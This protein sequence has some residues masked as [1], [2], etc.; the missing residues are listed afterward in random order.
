[1]RSEGG[2]GHRD[3]DL[4]RRLVTHPAEPNGQVAREPGGQRVVLPL[5]PAPWP[6]TAGQ[7]RVG[8]VEPLLAQAARRVVVG[9]GI[10]VPGEL[11]LQQHVQPLPALQV[12]LTVQP[13]PGAVGRGDQSQSAALRAPA[14]PLLE[15]LRQHGVDQHA[16]ARSELR[17]L[18]GAREQHDRCF[19]PAKL[20][21]AR[22]VHLLEL[23]EEPAQIAV[24][25]APP[26]SALRHP[27]RHASQQQPVQNLLARLPV[28]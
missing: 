3:H 8:R 20:R 22:L 27:Q 13:P 18:D 15:L 6:R 19:E 26:S 23:S 16:E 4:H 9:D 24:V 25:V 1:M 21:G 28:Q 10:L 2:D 5:A 17:R 7:L 12:E 11:G 14:G